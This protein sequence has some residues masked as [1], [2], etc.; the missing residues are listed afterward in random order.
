MEKLRNFYRK[1]LKNYLVLLFVV[2]VGIDL[3]IET[4]ARHSLIQSVAFFVGHPLVA[5]SNVLLIFAIISLSMLFHRRI[6]A[7]VLLCEGLKAILG[8]IYVRMG[9][10][11]RNLASQYE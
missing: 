1:Y 7:L 2:A 10:W 3:V 8:G 5:I 6:F 9:K 4:L 11:V